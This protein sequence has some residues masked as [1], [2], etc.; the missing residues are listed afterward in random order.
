MWRNLDNGESNGG[1]DDVVYGYMA[2]FEKY[3][4]IYIWVFPKIGGPPNH[5]F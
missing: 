4:C 5:Q 3:V 1:L 2:M